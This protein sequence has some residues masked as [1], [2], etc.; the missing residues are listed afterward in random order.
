MSDMKQLGDP[1]TWEDFVIAPF[2]SAMQGAMHSMFDNI[3]L[4][5]RLEKVRKLLEE[6]GCD[7]ECRHHKDEHNSD[8]DICLACRIGKAVADKY[9]AE[10]DELRA[11]CDSW[12]MAY[13]SWQDWATGLL[14]DLGCQPLHGELGDGPARVA[15]EQLCMMAKGVP[16]C[17]NCG[18]FSSQHEPDGEELRECINC[19]CKQYEPP[20]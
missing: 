16:R 20:K 14:H 10:H 2:S 3:D 11:N 17:S 7:C 6:N 8:C 13:N 12:R 9:D 1:V 4:Y 18:C 15:I 19:E 5:K